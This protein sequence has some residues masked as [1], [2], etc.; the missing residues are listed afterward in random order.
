MLEPVVIPEESRP[1]AGLTWVA[2]PAPDAP[3]DDRSG[4]PLSR[5]KAA[6]QAGRRNR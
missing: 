4:I 3:A 6:F 2:P 1:Q 5:T